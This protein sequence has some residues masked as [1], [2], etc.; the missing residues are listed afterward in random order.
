MPRTCRE[1]SNAIVIATIIS[2][3]I[4]QKPKTAVCFTAL[5]NAGLSR[6]RS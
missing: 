5:R 3:P 4:A 1:S 2:I 6:V